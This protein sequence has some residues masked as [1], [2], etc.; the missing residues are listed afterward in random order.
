MTLKGAGESKRERAKKRKRERE[1]KREKALPHPPPTTGTMA[2][3][4]EEVA[5][6]HGNDYLL[7]DSWAEEAQD[8]LLY[9]EERGRLVDVL[10]DEQL[11]QHNS[12][13]FFSY[14]CCFCDTGTIQ[15]HLRRLHVS[16]EV[17]GNILPDTYEKRY[18]PLYGRE[19]LQMCWGEFLGQQAMNERQPRF[20]KPV[21]ND[22][23]FEG[24]VLNDETDFVDRG[25]AVP[26][27]DTQIY[28]CT[29][30]RFLSEARL[31]VGGK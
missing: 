26:S 18:H 3:S 14:R 4:S 8:I 24:R 15:Y 23:C 28:V 13:R 25:I 9:A 5:K 31:L 6:M 30:V 7:E 11:L 21:G 17:V 19:V 12:K 16:E 2:A 29:P 22:K 20:V 1:R 27:D 10:T